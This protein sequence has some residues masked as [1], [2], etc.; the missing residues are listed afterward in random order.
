MLVIWIEVC[1]RTVERLPHDGCMLQSV[2]VDFSAD[3]LIVLMFQMQSLFDENF[4]VF[5]GFS[6]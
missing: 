1:V 4:S 6:N 2:R 3:V 5:R